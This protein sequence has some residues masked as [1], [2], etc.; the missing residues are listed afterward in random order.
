M[1]H[2][3]E[4]EEKSS[5]IKQLSDVYTMDVVIQR[6]VG[7]EVKRWID[8]GWLVKINCPGKGVIL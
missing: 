7:S 4:L 2:K 8:N 5:L 1:V 6:S 3:M